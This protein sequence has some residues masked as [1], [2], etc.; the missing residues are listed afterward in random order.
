MAF[1]LKNKFT[2][3][4]VARQLERFYLANGKTF[5]DN[6]KK[7]YEIAGHVRDGGFRFW[8]KSTGKNR[9]AFRPLLAGTVTATPHG[10]TIECAYKHDRVEKTVMLVWLIPLLLITLFLVI[11]G[12]TTPIP[13]TTKSQDLYTAL[14]PFCMFLI[15]LLWLGFT[16]L[17]F[18][19][20]SIL[21]NF[22][23]TAL[24]DSTIE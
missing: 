19:D 4:Q 17:I 1:R 23:C 20:Y 22:V 3:N 18:K 16:R 14:L 13:G 21:K 9:I 11:C 7:N 8:V 6:K 2:P 24:K 5:A 15:T 12:L 10:S